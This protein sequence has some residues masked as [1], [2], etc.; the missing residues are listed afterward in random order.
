MKFQFRPN[1]TIV[2]YDKMLNICTFDESGFYETDD[3]KKIKYLTTKCRGVKV[4]GET[5][6]EK[7]N[8]ETS[9]EKKLPAD[10]FY[11]CQ[12]CDYKTTNKGKLMAH[13]R[14]AHPKK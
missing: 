5:S 4:V 10:G 11:N 8:V 13:Y 7:P 1:T 9:K 14:K 6:E 3:P 12:K 2:D